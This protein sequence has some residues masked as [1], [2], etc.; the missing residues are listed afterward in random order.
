MDNSTCAIYTHKYNHIGERL[1]QTMACLGFDPTGKMLSKNPKQRISVV[2][3][4]HRREKKIFDGA[5]FERT[6]KD[7]RLLYSRTVDCTWNIRSD[8]FLYL[9]IEAQI[10]SVVN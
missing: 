4:A 5:M 7:S 9:F 1:G 2:F 8:H 10:R 3:N 6:R